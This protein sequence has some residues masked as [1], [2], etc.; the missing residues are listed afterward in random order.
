MRLV[1][2]AD[3]RQRDITLTPQNNPFISPKGWKWEGFSGDDGE[4][5]ELASKN[6]VVRWF[7]LKE[8]ER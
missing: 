4:D 5:Y 2:T 6:K 8:E 3:P 1:P 7:I